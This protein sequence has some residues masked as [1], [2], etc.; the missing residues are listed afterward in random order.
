MW[1]RQITSCKVGDTIAIACNRK[2]K[3]ATISV[4][5]VAEGWLACNTTADALFP[6]AQILAPSGYTLAD[7]TPSGDLPP[8]PPPPPPAPPAVDAVVHSATVELFG[9][10]PRFG[11]YPGHGS[12]GPGTG[13]GV[14]TTPNPLLQARTDQAHGAECAWEDGEPESKDSI[15]GCPSCKDEGSIEPYLNCSYSLG[16]GAHVN[17]NETF[18]SFRVMSLATDS[19]DVE[20]QALAGHRTTQLLAPHTTENPG[21]LLQAQS[22][23]NC[24]TERVSTVAVFFHATDVSAAGF[25]ATID[26]MAEVGFEMLIFSFG[27]G[28]RLETA[29]PEYLKTIKGQISYAHSKGIEVGGYDLICLDRGNPGAQYGEHWECEGDEGEACFASGWYDKLCECASQLKQVQ[30]NSC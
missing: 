21:T 13:F 8:P 18:V 5:G 22:F 10:M 3:Q 15:P 9:A 6:R 30:L 12:H 28:F 25:K 4:N 27:S 2:T 14:G 16:P 19:D 17:D 20:R 26:Q 23:S 1:C 29:D 7:L 24:V 11:S